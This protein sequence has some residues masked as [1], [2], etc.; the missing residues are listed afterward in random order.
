[1]SAARRSSQSRSCRA[2]SSSVALPQPHTL[3]CKHSADFWPRVELAFKC[4]SPHGAQV[5]LVRPCLQRA[6]NCKALRSP[7]RRTAQPWQPRPLPPPPLRRC[8]SPPSVTAGM[9][10]ASGV[11]QLLDLPADVLIAISQQLPFTERL[12]L[13]GVCRRLRQ[14]CAGPSPLWRRVEV[15]REMRPQHVA[16]KTRE[17]ILEWI[18]NMERAL[19]MC[20]LA[21][22]AAAGSRRSSGAASSCQGRL[23][24]LYAIFLL[25]LRHHGAAHTNPCRW[26]LPR[27]AA[28]EDLSF[29]ALGSEATLRD[30]ALFL[31]SML[32][33]QML[34]ALQRLSVQWPGRVQA[35][36]SAG[37]LPALTHLAFPGG[38]VVYTTFDELRGLSS[39][40]QFE[41]CEGSLV[42]DAAGVDHTT[43]WL[44]PSVTSVCLSS[45]GFRQLPDTLGR[46]PMLR[47][48]AAGCCAGWLGGGGLQVHPPAA[49][50][51]TLPA[52]L[53]TLI[54]LLLFSFSTAWCFLKTGWPPWRAWPC[55]R[56]W[57]AHSR[58]ST[59]LSAAC[60]PSPP[61]R[62]RAAGRET[63]GCS[64]SS[65]RAGCAQ[66]AAASSVSRG[67]AAAA[68][69]CCRR[70]PARSAP[71]QPLQPISHPARSI[72]ACLRPSPPPAAL[73]PHPPESPVSPQRL[74]PLRGAGTVRLGGAAAA[75]RLAALP[76]HLRQ[77]PG[78]AAGAGVGHV[79]PAGGAGG[80]WGWGWRPAAPA[81]L[82]LGLL[83]CHAAAL[84]KCA[85][86]PARWPP[87]PAPPSPCR[88]CTKRACPSLIPAQPRPR[89][90]PQGLH[91]EDNELAG[92]LPLAPFL[93]SLRELLLDWQAA[94][95]SPP[96]LAAATRLS[97]LVL[98]GHRAVDL[99][100]DGG[101]TV[102]PAAA[103]EPL[104]AALA[105][106]PTLR[107][108]DDIQGEV[109]EALGWVVA[110]VFAPP[111][112]RA[113]RGWRRQTHAACGAPYPKCQPPC[114]APC[115]PCMQE[116]VVT[117]PVAH[118]MWH[119]GRRLGPQ[120]G[121]CPGLPSGTCV[122]PRAAR[123]HEPS[124]QLLCGRCHATQTVSA[125]DANSAGGA[126]RS[127]RQQP[128]VEP[129]R[130]GGGGGSGGNS[131]QQA[132]E[133][134]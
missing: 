28:V 20:A 27:A 77:R 117:A 48:Q 92:P 101:L 131:M 121:P 36:F 56:G 78:S 129:G 134:K 85:S 93:L 100:A 103:A 71:I 3:D 130:S 75:G 118:A 84:C 69:A 89:L 73:H 94:L 80:C 95:D 25:P 97:R 104:L 22:P 21:L 109:S 66:H 116:D 18:F 63:G 51:P 44:A 30:C 119:M 110:G 128:G 11:L 70:P 1:M 14:L 86:C 62:A 108:V 59:S 24:V 50:A 29:A 106:M 26:L 68:P 98:N 83:P 15:L 132:G 55:C 39:L 47:R 23:A 114:S 8:H 115:G 133:A 61:R 64:S 81:E 9:A 45:A 112:Q 41:L 16:G 19:F 40:R 49:A 111:H 127:A 125:C 17:Q 120:V 31:D 35:Y 53:P 124:F 72:P 91:I 126:G 33:P 38:S 99:H 90:P 67:P 105:A 76:V 79:A 13:S 2:H 4:S 34:T 65:S 32:P 12:R 10:P 60:V 46:L 74:A 5:M 87:R 82:G 122:P 7:D 6:C 57:R 113:G 123:C 96:A 88:G 52:W 54:S 102:R 107:R 43:P 42:L 58:S 37:Q